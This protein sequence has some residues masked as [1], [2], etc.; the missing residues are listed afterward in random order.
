MSDNKC[1]HPALL[2]QKAEAELADLRDK[3]KKLTD[4]LNTAEQSAGRWARKAEEAERKL[5]TELACRCSCR[6]DEDHR[7]LA[8]CAFHALQRSDARAEGMEAAAKI[9]EQQVQR[10]AGYGGRWEGYGSFMEDK[11]GTECARDI[12]AAKERS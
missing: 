1:V 3:N 5:E 7:L 2:L 12:R 11:T 9:C 6:F 4:M 8:T 10:P